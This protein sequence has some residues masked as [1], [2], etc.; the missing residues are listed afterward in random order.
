MF[1]IDA[2]RLNGGSRHELYKDPAWSDWLEE[3][4]ATVW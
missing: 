1:S 3:S 4:G 2:P